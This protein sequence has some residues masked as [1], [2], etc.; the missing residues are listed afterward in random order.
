MVGQFGFVKIQTT[1]S[2]PLVHPQSAWNVRFAT[3]ARGHRRRE[4]SFRFLKLLGRL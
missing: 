3:A 1:R 2:A 4:G